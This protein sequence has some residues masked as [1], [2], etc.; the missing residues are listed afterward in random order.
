[1]FYV[2]PADFG[3]V[4]ATPEALQ[5]ADA[6][7]NA[8]IVLSVLRGEQ[9]PARDVVLL[10]AGAALFVAGLAATVKDGIA[11]SAAAIDT[12]AALRVLE[13]LIAVSN[14]AGAQS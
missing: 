1:T 13:R 9:G 10:N 5:G 7:T 4:K 12:G 11:K 3:L 6:P 2:H 8:K 14:R